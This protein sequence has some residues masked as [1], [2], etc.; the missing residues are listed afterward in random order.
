MTKKFRVWDAGR[1]RYLQDTETS[2]HAFTDYHITFDGKIRAVEGAISAPDCMGYKQDYTHIEY[3]NPLKITKEA[4]RF[5]IEQFTGIKDH[6]GTEIY[7]GDIISLSYTIG[8]ERDSSQDY[9]GNYI[10]IQAKSG[11]WMLKGPNPC[12][13]DKMPDDLSLSLEAS[14]YL[15]EQGME[16]FKVIGNIHE[17]PNYLK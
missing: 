9:Y 10:V 11:E 3:T 2:L 13:E 7:E 5:V 17:N 1:K 6:N 8:H 4:D 16:T 14:D 15:R 12:Y